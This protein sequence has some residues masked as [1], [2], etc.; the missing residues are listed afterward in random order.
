[1]KIS[2]TVTAADKLV[3]RIDVITDFERL[4]VLGPEVGIAGPQ[5]L[6]FLPATAGLFD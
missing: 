4:R 2:E 5:I 1:L 3:F 6:R